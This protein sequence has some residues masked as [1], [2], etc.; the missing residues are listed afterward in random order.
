MGVRG[1]RAAGGSVFVF[2]FNAFRFINLSILLIE[3]I[4]SPRVAV[5]PFDLLVLVLWL[6]FM[7]WGWC[8]IYPPTLPHKV[9]RHY[10]A[11][12]R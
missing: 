9:G 10:S 11:A 4:P 12:A 3:M 7:W 2:I 8:D 5:L 6:W 1:K